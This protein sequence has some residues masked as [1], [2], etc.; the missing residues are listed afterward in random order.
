[1]MKTDAKSLLKV[2]H[3]DVFYKDFQAIYD[4][5]LDIK[6]GSITSIIGANGAGKSTLLNTIM[7]INKPK[8]GTI[9]MD[10]KPIVGL[11]TNKIVSMGLAMSPEG[12]NVFADM[13][14]KEN[15]LIGAYLPHAKKQAPETLKKMFELFPILDEKQ[16]QLASFLSGGQR[17][18][19]AIAR[20]LMSL[21]RI[22]ICDEISLGLA[23]TIIKDIYVK[24]KEVNALGTTIILVEQEVKRSLRYSDYSYVIVKGSV[25]MEGLSKELS[26]EEV[27]KA[28]FG[29]TATS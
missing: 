25:A 15:L 26:E 4:I 2:E 19:L 23:P 8:A 3:L 16:D 21:P 20:A 10:G 9:T 27:R 1:M 7:G 24:I 6:E 5:S 17:Q 11:Q 12:S 29:I 14:V 13:T 18:I 22:I 28:Y